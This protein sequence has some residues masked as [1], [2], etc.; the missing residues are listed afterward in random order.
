MPRNPS[1]IPVA[2]TLFVAGLCGFVLAVDAHQR[3]MMCR[4]LDQA[5]RARAETRDLLA[6]VVEWGDL[7]R[8]RTRWH[9]LSDS[10]RDR[11][12]R[13]EDALLAASCEAL[14]GEAS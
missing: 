2:L 5:E 13:A 8:T 1:V 14:H 4:D 9:E 12:E 7:E 11:L 10:E 3:R 6:L